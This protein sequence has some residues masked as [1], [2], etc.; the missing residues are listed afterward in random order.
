VKTEEQP[1]LLETL[2]LSRALPQTYTY[3]ILEITLSQAT[4]F[5]KSSCIQC[6]V[7]AKWLLWLNHTTAIVWLLPYWW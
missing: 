2:R 3:Y 1:D 5:H 6:H 7:T 4:L